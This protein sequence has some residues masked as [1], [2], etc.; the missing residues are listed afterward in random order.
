MA[1]TE[2]EEVK[3]SK[4]ALDTVLGQKPAAYSSQWKNQMDGIVN[5]ILNREKFNYDLNGDALYQQYKDTAMMQGKLGMMDVMGQASAMTGGHSNSWAQ[6]AGQKTMQTQ[7]Q[8]LNDKIPQLYQM[9]LDTYNRQ[10]EDLYQKYNLVG[11]QEDQDY[12]RYM[13]SVN[14]WQSDRD[15]L[16]D[17]FQADRTFDYGQYRDSVTDSQWKKDFDEAKRRWDLS[18]AD[19]QA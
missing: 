12:G 2:N 16:N 17:R 5:K 15:Y 8:G 11:T 9:A 7:L 10:G 14:Q 6:T 3:K 19:S 4:T 1:Y 13:D 18:W